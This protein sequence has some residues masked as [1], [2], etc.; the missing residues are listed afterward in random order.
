MSTPATQSTRFERAI[1]LFDDANAA[2]P[3]SEVVEGVAQPKELVYGRRMS[4][5]LG[6]FAPDAPE[7][8]QLAVRAQHICRWQVPRDSYPMDR[9]GY[10]QW[11]TGLY[12]F[13]A[14][15][16]A[17]LMQ[18]AGCEAETIE[19]ARVAISKKAL[20][21]NADTQLL[22]DTADL[23]FIEYYMLPFAGSKPDYTEEKWLD[24]IRKTWKKMSEDARKFALSGAV[25][26]PEPLAPLIVRAIEGA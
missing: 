26:L 8:V 3:N 13:H 20:K 14:E 16:A 21:L 25:K 12:K 4:E 1:V 7:A 2:D 5:M 23:V 17:K 22:E 18:E 10:L 9:N 6:R 11:R 15:T 24:I 19:R